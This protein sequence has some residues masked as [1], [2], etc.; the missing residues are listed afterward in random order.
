MLAAATRAGRSIVWITHG[1]VG[2]DAMD[3]VVRLDAVGRAGVSRP[4][5]VGSAAA[6]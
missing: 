3:R 6:G 1:S 5:L 4:A 2:L